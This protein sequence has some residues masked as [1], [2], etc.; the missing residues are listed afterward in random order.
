MGLGRGGGFTR[1][2]RSGGGDRIHDIGLAITPADL[3]VRAHHF[4]DRHLL[5]PQVPG[6]AHP[7]RASALDPHPIH[8]TEAAHPRQ[9][10]PIANCSR[11]EL[12]GSQHTTDSA[13]DRCDVH[14]EVG[15]D[16]TGDEGRGS[17]IV[18]MSVLWLA[19]EGR[20][21]RGGGRT[22]QGRDA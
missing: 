15:V 6:Q 14:V 11:R 2:H 21:R 9:Q 5:L 22:V 20:A 17:A 7:V 16:A 10:A 13:Q 3:P 18:V 1:Q 19:L 12:G 8:I 4:N